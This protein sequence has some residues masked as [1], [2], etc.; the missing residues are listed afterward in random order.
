VDTDEASV[1]MLAMETADALLRFQALA[2]L[3]RAVQHHA[4]LLE[5]TLTASP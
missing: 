2:T 4:A 5:A 3:R 1:D